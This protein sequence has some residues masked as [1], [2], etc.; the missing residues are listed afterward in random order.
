MLAVS[1]FNPQLVFDE[2]IPAAF[3]LM[4]D[5]FGNYVIQKFFDFGTREQINVSC[6][7]TA[8][9]LHATDLNEQNSRACPA[10]ISPDVR[11]SSYSE[12]SGDRICV[13]TSLFG[14]RARRPCS[15]M[16]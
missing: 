13:P 3:Q 7:V 8:L 4:T 2:I 16:R 14:G 6:S 11:M 10:A 12:G 1:D 15:E 9:G 5:V